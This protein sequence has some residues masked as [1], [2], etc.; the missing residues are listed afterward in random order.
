MKLSIKIVLYHFFLKAFVAYVA[1]NNTRLA[2]SAAMVT[3]LNNMWTAWQNKF[4]LYTDPATHG[5]GSISDINGLFN[6]NFI[7]TEGVKNVLR[8]N[9][10]V[11]LTGDD[12]VSLDIP[13]EKAPRGHVP[14][15]DIRPGVA[16]ISKSALMMKLFIFNPENPASKAKVKDVFSIGYKMVIVAAGGTPPNP[17]DYVNQIPEKKTIFE[18]FFIT[19][20]VG[21]TLYIIPYYLNNRNEPGP[22][23]EP[24]SV[25]II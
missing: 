8:N 25:V 10:L 17:R 18:L 6:T 12:R 20:H 1:A 9:P 13:A 7:Y 21:S 19:G 11:T 24:F 2:I 15:P 16:L 4:D 5:P 23:G 22:D 3:S 14:T